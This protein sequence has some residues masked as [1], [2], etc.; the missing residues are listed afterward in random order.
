MP[1]PPAAG[2]EQARE[3]SLEWQPFGPLLHW[4][5]QEKRDLPWR[6]TQDPYAILVSEVML[7]QTRVETVIPYYHRFLERFPNLESLAQADRE[8]LNAA[9]AGL[10]YYRRAHSLQRAAQAILERGG[11]PQTLEELGQLPGIGPY[12]A[13]ALASIAFSQPALALDGNA[14]RV[15]SRWLA[16]ELPLG[17]LQRQLTQRL[18][19]LIPSTC[20]SDFTQ[21]VMELGARICL[22]RQ[23]RC[24]ICPW[25]HSCLA[26]AN[27]RI[28]HI[29]PPKAKRQRQRVLL[30]AL[31]I[32]HGSKVWL[33]RRLQ[34]PFLAG[35]WVPP[36]FEGFSAEILRAYTTRFPGQPEQ[37]GTIH[38]NVTY[39]DLEISI[40]DWESQQETPDQLE[41]SWQPVSPCNYPSLTQKVLRFTR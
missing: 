6:R 39:R 24:L 1:S 26:K 15:L 13:A 29:P 5:R 23:P 14:V 2:A 27:G 38:H 40:W 32:R 19:P 30:M 33:E 9:W 16:L 41:A 8:S 21:A 17:P 11:F 10:G 3:S 22:P 25:S 36:W 28:E 4:Y 37:I 20:A 34:D 7:Q 35:Q 31:R 12:T 18:Q